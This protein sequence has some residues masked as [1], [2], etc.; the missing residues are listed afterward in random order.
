MQ[1]HT[2]TLK[3]MPTSPHN[4]GHALIKRIPERHMGDNTTLKEGERANT[5]RPVNN[6]G[7]DDEITGLDLLLQTS[8]SGEG[9]DGAHADGAQGGDVGARGDLMRR[10]LVVHTVAAEEGHRD[11]L[12]IVVALV[13][14]DGDRG[15]RLAPGGV[16]VQRG[17][18]GEAGEF[19]QACSADDGD[20]D[21][22]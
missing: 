6:L 8:D 12:V 20:A 17:N 21:G 11:G 4:L 15:G 7:R 18:L 22:V 3:T 9:H 10:N 14:E 13:V 19:T 5:L 1:T 2:L 16:D